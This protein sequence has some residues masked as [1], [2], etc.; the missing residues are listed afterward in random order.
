MDALQQF[1][2]LDRQQAIVDAQHDNA[3]RAQR[4]AEEIGKNLLM[5]AAEMEQYRNG[6]LLILEA[7]RSAVE[8]QQWDGRF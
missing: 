7:I 8:R 1:N 3:I 4:S 2:D 6:Y 5:T